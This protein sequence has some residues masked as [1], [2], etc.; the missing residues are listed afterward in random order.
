MTAYTANRPPKEKKKNKQLFYIALILLLI[1]ANGILFYTNLQ[2]RKQK[3]ALETEKTILME[4]KADF[5]RRVDS[6]KIVLLESKGLNI[7]L[8]SIINVKIKELD[9]LK[10]SFNQQLNNKNYE[11]EKLKKQLQQKIHDLEIKTKL[12]TAEIN[13]WKT[14]Y[15][16]VVEEKGELEEEIVGKEK[17]I[18]E[19][20]KVIDKGHILA[21]INIDFYGSQVKKNEKEKRN[22]KAKRVNKLNICFNIAENRLAE[23][24]NKEFI[25]RIIGPNGNTIADEARGSGTFRLN[26]S[27]DNILYTTRLIISY[28]PAEV[29]KQYCADW[30]QDIDYAPGDYFLEIYQNGYLIGSGSMVLKKGGIF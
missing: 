11:I 21:A 5:E 27:N 20:K 13:D 23:P 3:A 2:H 7:E 18:D 17:K 15:D 30:M 19:L 14:K 8:D 26:N 12:Y 24:G 4:Q 10:T 22:D 29:S 6:F 1:I 28:D 25:I 16:I 9:S